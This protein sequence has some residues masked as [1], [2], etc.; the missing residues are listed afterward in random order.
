MNHSIHYIDDS[1]IV[2]IHHQPSGRVVLSTGH[3]LEAM[4]A[5]VYVLEELSTLRTAVQRVLDLDIDNTAY[6][7]I[8]DAGLSQDAIDLRNAWRAVRLAM[9]DNTNAS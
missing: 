4:E 9:K 5:L 6:E 2:E 1:R 3:V 8:P 7:S